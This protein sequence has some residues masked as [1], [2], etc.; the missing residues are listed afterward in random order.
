MGELRRQSKVGFL[1]PAISAKITVAKEK[2]RRRRGK[3]SSCALSFFPVIFL[4]FYFRDSLEIM[5]SKPGY[6]CVI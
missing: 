2:E 4:I 5:F 6:E 3:N 1:S